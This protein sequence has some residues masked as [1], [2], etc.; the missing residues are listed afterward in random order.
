MAKEKAEKEEKEE[1][2]NHG[3]GNVAKVIHHDGNVKRVFEF[4]ERAYPNGDYLEAARAHFAKLK[5]SSH[6]RG[7]LDIQE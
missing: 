6:F 3:K 7:T 1:L 4:S 5:A 2:G